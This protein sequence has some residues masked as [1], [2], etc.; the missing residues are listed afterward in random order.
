MEERDEKA[1]VG[2]VPFP[3]RVGA[4][5]QRIKPP[6]YLQPYEV[7]KGKSPITVKMPF[8]FS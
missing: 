5:P 1:K 6:K 4:K 2:V 7:G 8:V 3:D